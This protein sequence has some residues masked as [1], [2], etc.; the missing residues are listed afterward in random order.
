MNIEKALQV[1]DTVAVAI[2]D[3][4]VNK[5]FLQNA[6]YGKFDLEL[7]NHLI[8]KWGAQDGDFFRY[9]M[10]SGDTQQRLL[11][12]ALGIDVEPDKYPDYNSRI[13]AQIV[14]GVKKSDIHPFETYS[15][16]LLLRFFYNHS[17]DILKEVSADA[18][19]VVQDNKIDRY[20]NYI[21]WSLW[22][23]LASPSDKRILFEYIEK[24]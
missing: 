19:Q 7:Y 21:N 16:F 9:Y 1:M 2:V 14:G 5:S 6:F 8:H 10:D 18:W 15:L 3:K 13:M 23:G 20:G 22:W 4:T 17:L 12:E 24:D 11:L